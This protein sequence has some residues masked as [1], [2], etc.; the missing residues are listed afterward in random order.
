MIGKKQVNE[1]SLFD[2][3]LGIS[4][5]NFAADMTLDIEG[6]FFHGVIAVFIFGL[7]GYIISISTMKSIRLRRFFMG[8]PTVVIENGE[9]LIKGL[10]KVKYDIN[11]LLEQCRSSGYFDLSD[12][13]YAIVEPN[14][15]LS[16][17]SNKDGKNGLCANVIIDG[18]YMNSN[19]ENSSITLDYLKD[20]IHK[21]NIDLDS[22]ILATVDEKRNICIYKKN[23]NEP[24]EVLE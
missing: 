18:K 22:I 24:T 2:Y 8:T 6:N 17:L 7:V 21:Q 5:G 4:I 10:R 12:I 3:V 1:L 16:I 13:R 19:I 14:G 20:E 11:D 9:L 15:Q 23:N